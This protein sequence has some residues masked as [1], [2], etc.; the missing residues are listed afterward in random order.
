MPNKYLMTVIHYTRTPG[1][2]WEVDK[3]GRETIDQEAYN[4][5]T[6]PEWKSRMKN[7]GSREVFHKGYTRFGY[8]VTRTVSYA[9]SKTAKVERLFK[10]CEQ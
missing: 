3:W 5:Y 10:S 2:N 1:K 6:S 8:I 4:L 7:T 9:P